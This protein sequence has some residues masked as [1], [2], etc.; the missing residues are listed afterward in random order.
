LQLR[1]EV[2]IFAGQQAFAAMD[3]GDLTAEAAKH[4]AEF[5]ANVAAAENEQMLGNFL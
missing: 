3:N 5:E 2:F 4:L 1:H